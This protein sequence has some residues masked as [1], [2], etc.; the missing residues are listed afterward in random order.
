MQFK[1]PPQN[2]P[3]MLPTE[4]QMRQK[5]N[6][7]TCRNL[8]VNTTRRHGKYFGLGLVQYVTKT[9]ASN[10][11]LF[12]MLSTDMWEA[13]KAFLL[14]QKNKIFEQDKIQCT[15]HW[16]WGELKTRLI[17]RWTKWGQGSRNTSTF[18]NSAWEIIWLNCKT[19][20]LGGSA[21][22]ELGGKIISCPASTNTA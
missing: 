3:R 5:K 8:K 6:E 20:Q 14:P 15:S 10:K 18:C 4:R 22:K 16:I 1:W 2:K 11:Q 9:I 17:N 19:N 12:Y 13:T 21:T 7:F